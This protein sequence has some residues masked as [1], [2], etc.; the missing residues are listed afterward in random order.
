MKS[1]NLIL[2]T[3]LV[4]LAIVVFGFEYTNAAKEKEIYP[5]KIGVVSIREVFENCELKKSIETA[6]AAEGEARFNQLKA[7]EE[8]IE[9]GKV[10]LSKR[11][12]GSEDY[13]EILEQM[14]LKQSEIEA[15]KEFYQQT[16]ALKEMQGKEKIYRKALEVITEVA[17]AK[18]L[19]MVINR[20]DNY[21]SM[22]DVL[23]PAQSPSDLVLTT[24]THKLYY[25]N[26]ELDITADVT[27]AINESK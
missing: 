26:K 11:K 18:G 8:E 3:S 27:I 21:L 9:K 1:K 16:L 20:D 10:S 17:K 15:K 23:P 22:P 14:T 2:S 13:M 19:D 6:L 12:Q 4:V 25:F 24:R 5:P 7:I